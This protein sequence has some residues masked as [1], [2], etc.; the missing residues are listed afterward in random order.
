MWSVGLAMV[1]AS[2]LRLPA[3]SPYLDV[4][5]STN[6]YSFLQYIKFLNLYLSRQDLVLDRLSDPL[7]HRLACLTSTG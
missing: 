2:L 6:H 5:I 1:R 4:G 7:H 3:A